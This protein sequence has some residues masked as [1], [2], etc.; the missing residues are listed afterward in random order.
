MLG[1][2]GTSVL[3]ILITPVP[4]SLAVKLLNELAQK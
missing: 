4:R 3:V 1:L 2:A